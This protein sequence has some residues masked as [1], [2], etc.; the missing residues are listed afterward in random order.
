ML[1]ILVIPVS[2]LASDGVTKTNKANVEILP[3]STMPLSLALTGNF[4]P[5][6]MASNGFL[7]YNAISTVSLF[8]LSGKWD[9]WNLTAE[10]TSLKN[11][12]YEF[13][14]GSLSLIEPSNIVSLNA[15]VV[16]LPSIS[17]EDKV[18]IDDGQVLVAMARNG[19]G[20]GS[21]DVNFDNGSLALAV[22]DDVIQSVKPD[23]G[24]Y[25]TTVSWTLVSSDGETRV[26]RSDEYEL[27]VD[28]D[29]LY[30][31]KEII[32]DESE[33]KGLEMAGTSTD[34]FNL[35]LM[36]AVLITAGILVYSI[37]R[38]SMK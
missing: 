24:V 16:E 25:N 8:D 10:A 26:L 5:T 21:F 23:S 34:I 3:N 19:L 11:E 32:F 38:K 9:G 33:K 31:G 28:T 15:N 30:E 37:R 29:Y 13:P 7:F 12:N 20:M 18:V 6:S 36:G 2:V 1:A 27:E 14:R 4:Y 22:A 35:L 17:L